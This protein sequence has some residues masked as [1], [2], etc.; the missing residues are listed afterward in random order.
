VEK[1]KAWN[2]AKQLV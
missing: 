1:R 2:D